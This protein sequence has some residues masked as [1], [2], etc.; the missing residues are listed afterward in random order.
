MIYGKEDYDA[1][2]LPAE[3]DVFYIFGKKFSAEGD[4]DSKF[5]NCFSENNDWPFK[6]LGIDKNIFFE[7]VVGK[8]HVRTVSANGP[9]PYADSLERLMKVVNALW[10]YSPFQEGDEVY[11]AEDIESG[12]HPEKYG[13]SVASDMADYA[14]ESHKIATIE[15]STGD[16]LKYGF[17]KTYRLNSGDGGYGWYWTLGM[18]DVAKSLAYNARMKKVCKSCEETT[19]PTDDDTPPQD[20]IEAT[21]WF[22]KKPMKGSQLTSTTKQGAIA[23]PKHTKHLKVTL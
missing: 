13:Y 9:S 7:G 15:D 5:L 10:E 23:L 1:G 14:G 16:A 6:Y 8:E 20:W 12:E 11:I 19:I 18:L 21:I 3:E 4:S 17:C 2:R 22:D